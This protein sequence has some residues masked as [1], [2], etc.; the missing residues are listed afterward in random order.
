MPIANGFCSAFSRLF[1]SGPLR[2]GEDVE[3]AVAVAVAVA[4]AAA[5]SELAGV[6]ATLR[7]RAAAAAQWRGVLS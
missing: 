5:I 3:A 7:S 6:T 1:P 4:V 2:G